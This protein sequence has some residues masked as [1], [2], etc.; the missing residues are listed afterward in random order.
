MTTQDATAAE[1][2]AA[3]LL[4]EGRHIEARDQYEHAAQIWASVCNRLSRQGETMLADS[5]RSN[6]RRCQR[7]ADAVIWELVP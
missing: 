2:H 4:S 5:F 7:K 6:V 1:N 3:E